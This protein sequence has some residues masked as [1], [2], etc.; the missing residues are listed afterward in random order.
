[1]PWLCLPFLEYHLSLSLTL[2]CSCPPGLV[3]YHQKG[4]TCSLRLSNRFPSWLA[5][6]IAF[7]KS[8]YVIPSGFWY[9]S[10]GRVTLVFMFHLCRVHDFTVCRGTRLCLFT[11]VTAYAVSHPMSPRFHT[12][13]SLSKMSPSHLRK[14]CRLMSTITANPS[15]ILDFLYLLIAQ[16]I[17]SASCHPSLDQSFIFCVRLFLC[18]SP[19]YS[20]LS[21]Q[22]ICSVG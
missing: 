17:P 18:K 3:C 15:F 5:E 21:S 14:T 19:T 1:M 22:Y 4:K 9:R 13:F 11:S 2:N 8:N 6:A 10:R 16:S 12:H 20:P 7:Y